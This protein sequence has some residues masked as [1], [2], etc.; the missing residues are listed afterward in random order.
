MAR[1]RTKWLLTWYTDHFSIINEL[2]VENGPIAIAMDATLLMSYD[3]GI[4]NP[5]LPSRWTCSTIA[6]DHALVIVGYGVQDSV[7]FWIVRVK[8][9]QEGQS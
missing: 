4:I 1:M 3:G 7:N 5:A 8:R 6:L 2:Q 9:K